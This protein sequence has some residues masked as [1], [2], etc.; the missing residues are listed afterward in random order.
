MKRAA[1]ALLLIATPAAAQDAGLAAWGRIYEV[2]SHPRCANCHVGAD[3]VP[4]WSEPGAQPRAHGMNVNAG[5]SRI[6][7][8]SIPCGTCHSMHNAELPHGPPGAP[9]WQ[10]PPASMQWFGR[11]S[12]EVCAQIKDEV[13]TMTIAGMVKHV[14]QDPLVAWGWA[15]GPGRAPAPYSAAETAAYLE[16]WDDAGAPCP[17]K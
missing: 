5:P 10:L 6:G 17:A 11:T 9:N 4:L 15:P 3:N 12:A 8:E 13:R 7:A 14:G 16:Q 1:L 2:L